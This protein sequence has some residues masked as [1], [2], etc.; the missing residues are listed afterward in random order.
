MPTFNVHIRYVD[1][2][3]DDIVHTTHVTTQK[4]SQAAHTATVA[5]FKEQAS[6]GIV[7]VKKTKLLREHGAQ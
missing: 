2:E 5:K 7:H 3:T 1:K 4:T 6:G